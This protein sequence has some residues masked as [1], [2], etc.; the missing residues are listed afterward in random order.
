[1]RNLPTKW[2]DLAPSQAHY[3]NSGSGGSVALGP[4]LPLEVSTPR[5]TYPSSDLEA[6][7]LCLCT[8]HCFRVAAGQPQ[9]EG[10]PQVFS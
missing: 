7:P 1:M 5:D 10:R 3:R 9:P 4:G 6:E 8:Q 2:L